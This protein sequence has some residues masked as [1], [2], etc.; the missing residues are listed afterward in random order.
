MNNNFWFI[1]FAPASSCSLQVE[2][3]M[4]WQN[5]QLK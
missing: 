3:I 4:S 2:T 1:I 5:I